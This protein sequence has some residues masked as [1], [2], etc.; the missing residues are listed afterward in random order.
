VQIR[1]ILVDYLNPST[2][3]ALTGRRDGCTDGDSGLLF[4]STDDG[5][6]WSNRVS[7]P[8]SYCEFLTFLGPIFMTMDPTNPS[9]LYL[10]E[11]TD[12]EHALTTTDDGGRNWHDVFRFAND[13]ADDAD[14]NYTL[15]ID[16]IHSVLY[17]GLDDYN[18][19][20]V[21]KS[22]DGGATW[23]RSGLNGAAVTVMA[24]TPDGSTIYASTEGAHS[25]PAGFR[26]LFKS[27][28]GGAN[29]AELTQG[30]ET[31]RDARIR[32]TSILTGP[33]NSNTVYL[34]T[35]GAGVFRST[36]AGAT[37][38][39]FND[40]LGNLNVR[41]LTMSR[42]EPAVLYAG[43]AGGLFAITLNVEAVPVVTGLG[44][45]RSTVETRTSYAANFSGNNLTDKTFFDIRFTAPGSNDSGVVLNWQTGTA[46]NH[47]VTAGTTPGSWTITGVRAHQ[48]ETD[49]DGNFVP[50]SAVITVVTR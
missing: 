36:N 27:T 20:G 32:V 3:Y 14:G 8:G 1:S 25:Q 49:H 9:R 23:T 26:G 5:A 46:A 30:L 34:G 41:V 6:T 10:G 48:I 15:A 18:E 38:S 37:W 33:L 42:G 45:D 43:T 22:V 39:P 17:R 47:S 35:A 29:W 24:I 11:Y 50:L 2:L 31:L 7:P 19:G 28:D 12:G 13:A 16:P 4:K 44:F 40:G 21:R